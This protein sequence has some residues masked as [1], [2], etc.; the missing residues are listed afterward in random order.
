MAAQTFL[1]KHELPASYLD[2]VVEFIHKS[3]NG[4][5]LGQESQGN[6]TYVD[7]YTG[8]SRYTGTTGTSTNQGGSDPFTG[9][10]TNPLCERRQL[11]VRWISLHWFFVNSCRFS[12]C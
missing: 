11:I 10:S 5:T 7:P 12:L 4:E 9:K 3:T 6:S 1:N 8:S 2:Q